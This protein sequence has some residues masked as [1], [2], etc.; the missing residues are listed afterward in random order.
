MHRIHFHLNYCLYQAKFSC[1]SNC[2]FLPRSTFLKEPRRRSLMICHCQKLGLTV[3]SL[4]GFHWPNWCGFLHRLGTFW[5]PAGSGMSNNVSFHLNCRCSFLC[6]S[7]A[8]GPFRSHTSWRTCTRCSPWCGSE[9]SSR[10]CS[11]SSLPWWWTG[12]PRRL[13]ALSFHSQVACRSGAWR[14]HRCR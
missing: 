4:T 10:T 3:R 14:E 12:L 5:N 8:H 11:W 6:Q 7:G 13:S 2:S 1:S 9:H